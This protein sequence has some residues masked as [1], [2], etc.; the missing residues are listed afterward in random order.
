MRNKY[1]GWALLIAVLL[2]SIL[3]AALLSLSMGEVDIKLKDIVS[4][5]RSGSGMEHTI[6]TQIRLPR[7]LLAF[8][9]GGALS[10]TGTIL[11]GVYRNPLVEPY[12]LGISGGAVFGVTLTIVLGLHLSLGTFMLPLSGFLG[13]M[14]TIFVVYFL[15]LKNR[16]LNVNRMLLIGVMISFVASSAMM[17]L[18]SVTSTENMR[19]IIFWTM[20]SLDEPDSSLIHIMLFTSVAGLLIS[21]IYAQPLNALRLGEAKAKHL[22]VNAPVI[23]K[24]LFFVSSMLTGIC[25]SVVGVIGFVGLIIPHLTRL[26]IGNDFRI[27]LI[28]SFLGGSLFLILC[29]IL[30]R[31]AIAPNE[32]PIGVITGMAGGLVFILVLSRA[33]IKS[34]MS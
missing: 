17:F 16:E 26:I 18:T 32:L 2:F 11:Q 22:G 31:T 19:N 4:I 28:G 9:A 24:I 15:S 13:A 1:L 7:I 14:I 21:I 25:V 23:I 30:A 12:T 33:R 10:L 20:G 6:L 27:T 3:G 8:S 5:L 34:K 29:D